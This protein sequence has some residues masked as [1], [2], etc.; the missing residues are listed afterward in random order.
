MLG[1]GLSIED[2]DLAPAGLDHAVAPELAHRL[3]DCLAGRGDHV[4]QV[5]MGEGDVDYSALPILLPEVFAEVQQQGRQAGRHLAIE[6]A[7]YD[8][9]GLPQPLGERGEEPQGKAWIA[10]Y[11]TLQRSL[12]EAGHP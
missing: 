5:L 8:L 2:G 7:L 9:V 12:L 1:E 4:R 6:K 10:L 3:R 11:D